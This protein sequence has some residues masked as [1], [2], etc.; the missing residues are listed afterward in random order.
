MGLYHANGTLVGCWADDEVVPRGLGGVWW[1]WFEDEPG[2][3]FDKNC[4]PAAAAAC[5]EV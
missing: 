4:C 2:V 3:E 1:L 5:M